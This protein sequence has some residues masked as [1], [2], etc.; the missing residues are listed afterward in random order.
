[1]T[2]QVKDKEERKLK[3]VKIGLMRNPKF[4]LWS[5][6]MMVG[7]TLLDDDVPTAATDGRDEFYGREFVK[8]LP[9]KQLAFVVLHEN[10]HKAL[11]H[12]TTWRKLYDEDPRLANI[13]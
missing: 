2:N 9:E 12:L 13:A 6:I 10:L 3:K 4:A 11:R 5:G 8:S 7:K 1:M